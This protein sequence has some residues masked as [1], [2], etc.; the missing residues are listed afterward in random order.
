MTDIDEN[1][2]R[3]NFLTKAGKYGNTYKF[4][5]QEDEIWVDRTQILSVLQKIS[6]I[7]KSK[8]LYKMDDKE[9]DAVINKF[10]AF[11]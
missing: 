8:R 1:D 10:E 9:T 5:P 6:A 3:I 4:P 7:G 2:Y 11:R